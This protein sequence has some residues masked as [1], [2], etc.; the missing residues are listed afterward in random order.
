MISVLP[1]LAV[2][3]SSSL[4]VSAETGTAKRCLEIAARA[5]S[6]SPCIGET[7]VSET[8]AVPA[9]DSRKDDRPTL[10]F[11]GSIPPA[12]GKTVNSVPAPD[13]DG[14]EVVSHGDGFIRGGQQGAILGLGG[15]LYPAV[16]LLSEGYGRAMSRSYDGPRSDNGYSGLYTAAGAILLF[17]LFVPA[18]VAGVVGAGIGAIA[19]AIAPKAAAKW[20]AESVLSD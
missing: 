2:A 5:G 6:L 16:S 12:T 9:A 4:G 11:Q 15:V 17:I 1:S 14:L 19:G 13:G 8:V 20:D 3:A 18:V 10:G 7:S